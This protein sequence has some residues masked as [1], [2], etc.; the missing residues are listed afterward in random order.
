MMLSTL[1]LSSHGFELVLHPKGL[2][3]FRMEII[4][5]NNYNP[6]FLSIIGLYNYP[7]MPLMPYSNTWYDIVNFGP[8]A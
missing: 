7:I 5:I 1:S 6:H 2:V 8:M 3:P 4:L